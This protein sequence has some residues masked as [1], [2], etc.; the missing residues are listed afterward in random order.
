[1]LTDGASLTFPNPGLEDLVAWVDYVD[2]PEAGRLGGWSTELTMFM[3]HDLGS[4][5]P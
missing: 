3:I 2:V 1:M 4:L 5:T